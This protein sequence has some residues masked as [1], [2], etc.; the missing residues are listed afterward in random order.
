ME[1]GQKK[2]IYSRQIETVEPVGVHRNRNPVAR[3]NHLAKYVSS[4]EATDTC[5]GNVGREWAGGQGG[6]ARRR[7]G[8]MLST[9]LLTE[10]SFHEHSRHEED[11]ILALSYFPVEMRAGIETLMVN[12]RNRGLAQQPRGKLKFVPIDAEAL[13][14]WW[15]HP[16]GTKMASPAC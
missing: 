9:K 1:L 4:K 6:K 13:P 11:V 15:C 3:V 2:G 10:W 12:K 7:N 16:E 14:T 8:A 5:H